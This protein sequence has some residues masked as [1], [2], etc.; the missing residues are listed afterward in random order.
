MSNF[1]TPLIVSPLPDGRRWKLHTK[2]TYDLDYEGSGTSIVVPANFITDFASIPSPFWSIIGSPW[3]RYG[4]AAIIHDYLYQNKT[5]WTGHHPV[6]SHLNWY[7]RPTRKQ[8]DLIFLQAMQALGVALWR[9]K[10]MYWG[11][12][13]FGWLAWK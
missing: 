6:D 8:V 5:F 9:R 11:V 2:F 13:L 1:K 10:F 12:R 7:A 3:G 4:K